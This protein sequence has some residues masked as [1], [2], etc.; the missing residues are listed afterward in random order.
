MAPSVLGWSAENLADLL[1]LLDQLQ[2]AFFIGTLKSP[3]EKA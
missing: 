2:Q 1:P 3:A